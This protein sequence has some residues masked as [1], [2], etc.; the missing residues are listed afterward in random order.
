MVLIKLTISFAANKGHIS[1]FGA[2]SMDVI[3]PL[4][5]VPAMKSK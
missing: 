2:V 4:V 3:R 5:L 1:S